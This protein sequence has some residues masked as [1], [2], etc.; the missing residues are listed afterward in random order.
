[1]RRAVLLLF[2]AGFLY[3]L[4][5]EALAQQRSSARS[6]VERAALQKHAREQHKARKRASRL[7]RKS[8][9]VRDRVRFGR[10][11]SK[12]YGRDRADR[13][14]KYDRYRYEPYRQGNNRYRYG[15]SGRYRYPHRRGTRYGPAFCRYGVGHPVFGLRWC[16]E[17]AFWVYG[18]PYW[19]YYGPFPAVYRRPYY[20]GPSRR[21]YRPGYRLHYASLV[22]L[23]GHTAVDLLLY[24][25]LRL[26]PASGNRVYGY[27]YDPRHHELGHHGTGYYDLGYRGDDYDDALAL[28]LYLDEEPLAELTD[29]DRDGRVDVVLMNN[30]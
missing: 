27:W 10:A 28:Q 16:H 2:A 29:F 12:V 15:F 6:R 22:D 14:S 25:V 18:R 7:E 21:A 3:G 30:R 23:L 19:T 1:M 5:S 17:K 13:R 8:L 20:V 9:S 26:G 11:A 4:P 24:E